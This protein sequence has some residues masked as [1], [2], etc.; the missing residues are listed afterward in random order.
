MAVPATAR[1]HGPVVIE[2]CAIATMD[3][4]QRGV[5]WRP[6]GDYQRGFVPSGDEPPL[7]Q[8][9][10]KIRPCGCTVTPRKDTGE[11]WPVNM[12]RCPR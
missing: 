7:A 3:G 11:M 5:R 6:T 4:R 1:Y 10:T 12:S 2:N 9:A 8:K